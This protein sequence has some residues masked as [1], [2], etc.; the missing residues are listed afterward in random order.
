MDED[1]K[2][3]KRM[4]RQPPDQHKKR[5]SGGA[6]EVPA[7]GMDRLRR[8]EKDHPS[9]EKSNERWMNFCPE[10]TLH[11]IQQ[12]E[13]R[14]KTLRHMLTRLEQNNDSLPT[15]KSNRRRRH[16]RRPSPHSP[17]VPAQE[18]DVDLIVCGLREEDEDSLDRELKGPDQ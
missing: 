9:N 17:L 4:D 18:P 8:A 11:E 1:R 15:H 7:V 13:E 5:R 2:E 6:Q 3:K 14:A 16:R 12:L 10:Q